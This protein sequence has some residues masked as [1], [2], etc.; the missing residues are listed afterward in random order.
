MKKRVAEFRNS[1]LLR[2][3][4]KVEISDFEIMRV[5]CIIEYQL[6]F[7]PLPRHFQSS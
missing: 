2:D 3:I 7:K 5:N 4:Q 6:D 1:V